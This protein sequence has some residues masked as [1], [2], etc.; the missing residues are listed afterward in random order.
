ME[1]YQG[2]YN[3]YPGP[4]PD[5][6]MYQLIPPTPPQM[7]ANIS[8]AQGSGQ[9]TQMENAVLGLMGGHF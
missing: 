7:P 1:A 9:M 5:H 4:I 3:A 8:G 2:T 6:F